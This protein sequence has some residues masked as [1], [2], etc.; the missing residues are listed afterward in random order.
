MARPVARD[1]TT[2]ICPSNRALTSSKAAPS[3]RATAPDRRCR[4]ARV[5]GVQLLVL[6]TPMAD[7]AHLLPHTRLR[8]GC[9]GVCGSIGLTSRAARLPGFIPMIV[10]KG[11]H[12][13]NVQGEAWSA[14]GHRAVW[15]AWN[16]MRGRS[17]QHIGRPPTAALQEA[18]CF[19]HW[20]HLGP[21]GGWMDNG[22]KLQ[23]A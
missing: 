3:T 16:Q 10:S 7:T 18:R 23:G 6:P 19:Q 4:K 14:Q 9:A 12:H 11:V 22:T 8:C 17:D 13:G 15:Q 5:S 1:K 2:E 20:P 21:V